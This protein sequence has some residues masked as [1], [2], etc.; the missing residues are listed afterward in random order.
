MVSAVRDVQF[1]QNGGATGLDAVPSHAHR[2][3]LSRE[4]RGI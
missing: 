2:K 3:R 1:L 4:D